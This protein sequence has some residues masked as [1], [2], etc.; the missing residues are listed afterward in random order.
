[1]SSN[2]L[3]YH[4]TSF[5]KAVS[6]ILPLK[7]LRF[8]K[9]K[10]SRDPIEVKSRIIASEVFNE[11]SIGDCVK[12][13]C[14]CEDGETP[15]RKGNH[16]ARMWAQ[17]GGDHTGVC[18]GF[19]KATLL[20]CLEDQFSIHNSGHLTYD[21]EDF[22]SIEPH[23]TKATV[24]TSANEMELIQ[25]L[26][27]TEETSK[28]FF[29]S[30]QYDYRDENEF[31]CIIFDQKDESFLHCS[32][33]LKTIT[34]GLC[35]SKVQEKIILEMVKALSLS[36]GISKLNFKGYGDNIALTSDQGVPVLHLIE[37]NLKIKEDPIF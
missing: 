29:F 37:D 1:M 34:L 24:Y 18:L 12:Y 7:Q 11:Y 10:D 14:F 2:E 6:Y 16:V 33:A 26:V 28:Y 8:S 32:D 23:T 20:K 21:L 36:V 27:T 9:F 4:Y 15:V 25:S 31:R 3:I 30:K 19:N 13:V 5:E 35:T 22:F 17:Y